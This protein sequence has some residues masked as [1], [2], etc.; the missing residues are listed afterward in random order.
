MTTTRSTEARLSAV[1]KALDLIFVRLDKLEG[2]VFATARRNGQ[3]VK[4][5][6]CDTADEALLARV[7]EAL[8]RVDDVE[9]VVVE[10]KSEIGANSTKMCEFE[11]SW[12][13]LPRKP[14]EARYAGAVKKAPQGKHS[15]SNAKNGTAGAAKSKEVAKGTSKEGAKS[16]LSKGG[17]VGKRAGNGRTFG[18]L[19]RS[20]KER[21]VVVGDSLARGVGSKLVRQCASAARFD[22]TSGANLQTI[23]EK[24]K[25][26]DE[27][28]SHVVM[29]AGA[30]NVKRGSTYA[31]LV[32]EFVEALRN[33]MSVK[34][35]SV[36]VVGL[37]K[38]YDRIGL[39][40]ERTRLAVNDKVKKL[41]WE[42]GFKYLGFDPLR[43]EV[44]DDGLHLNS[45][46]QD[47]L[48]RKIFKHCKSSCK[49]FLM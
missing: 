20:S 38:R 8:T 4:T 15:S 22:A 3:D 27:A 34:C 14:A 37:T 17:T 35:R 18:D 12:P 25:K 19:L 6:K 47:K 9:N 45:A 24:I 39:S 16:T 48:G 31:D 28:D 29:I 44:H 5:A 7:D 46:G 30:N 26:T 11:R 32:D 23:G 2:T 13:A 10:L 43:N 41:C 21:I 33:V 1:E 40:F 42:A 36:T 49:A